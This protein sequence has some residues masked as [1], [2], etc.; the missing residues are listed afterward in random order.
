V[1]GDDPIVYERPLTQGN[2]HSSVKT[3]GTSSATPAAA[4]AEPG[5]APQRSAAPRV[6][7]TQRMDDPEER[8][9]L[10]VQQYLKETGFT[11]GGRAWQGC[12]SG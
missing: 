8:A 3:P 4:R 10:Y 6:V 7:G 9:L 5:G 12:L 2:L 11:Q 1:S